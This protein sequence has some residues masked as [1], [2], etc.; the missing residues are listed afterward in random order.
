[1]IPVLHISLLVAVGMGTG[2]DYKSVGQTAMAANNNGTHCAM[3]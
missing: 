1:M 2:I 3:A